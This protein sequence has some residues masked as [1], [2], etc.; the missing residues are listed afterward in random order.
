[1]KLEF[2]WATHLNQD[3]MDWVFNL[4]SK[5]MEDMYR[6]SEWGYEETEKKNELGA[7]TARYIIARNAEGKNIAFMHYRFVIEANEPVLYCYELQVEAAYQNQG[8]GSL[9]L[10]MVEKVAKK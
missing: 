6:K 4:F 3:Q 5:N 7:T 2:Y 9:L 8:I 1:M 10:D